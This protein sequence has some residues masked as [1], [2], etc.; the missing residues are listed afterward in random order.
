M[1]KFFTNDYFSN[2]ISYNDCLVYKINIFS[3]IKNNHNILF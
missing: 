1:I 2:K 3:Y